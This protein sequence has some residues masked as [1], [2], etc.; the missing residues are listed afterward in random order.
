MYTKDV[1]GFKYDVGSLEKHYR[2]RWEEFKIDD[3]DEAKRCLRLFA[4][5]LVRPDVTIDITPDGTKAHMNDP[6]RKEV[7]LSRTDKS[8][9]VKTV[10]GRIDWEEK[11]IF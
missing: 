8:Y 4:T 1:R 2:L 11:I 10:K 6:E 5:S 9:L 7:V 3:G